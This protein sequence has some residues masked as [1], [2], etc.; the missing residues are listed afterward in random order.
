MEPVS[1]GR[2]LPAALRYGNR[3]S[4]QP[5]TT[6]T[7]LQHCNTGTWYRGAF[8]KG[9]RQETPEDVSFRI[10]FQDQ[11]MTKPRCLQGCCELGPLICQH[12]WFFKTNCL[13]VACQPPTSTNC[14]PKQ[15]VSTNPS[16]VSAY[17]SIVYDGIGSPPTPATPAPSTAVTPVIQ[18]LMV[19]ISPSDVITQDSD[20]LLSASSSQQQVYTYISIYRITT[21]GAVS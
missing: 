9:F 10:L 21:P 15:L 20:I 18:H 2:R 7:S 11:E 8:P 17:V 14:T 16:A 12:L 4:R 3:V 13:A 1:Q 5:S 19:T 6:Q